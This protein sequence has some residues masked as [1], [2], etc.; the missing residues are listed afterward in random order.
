MQ[1]FFHKF[2]HT[3]V[4]FLSQQEPVQFTGFTPLP[5][6]TEF[7]AHEEQFLAGMTEH[8]GI[9]HPQIG[10]FIHRIA[11]HLVHHGTFQMHHFIVGQGQDIFL[12]LIVTHGKGHA[13]VAAL[14][15]DG[16]QLHIF[17]EIVHP[18]H[19]P[20]EGESQAVSPDLTCHIGPGG[21]FFR[22]GEESRIGSPY[23]GVHVFE[24]FNGLQVLVAAE[25][26]GQPLA[27]LLT[28]VQI[29]H[30]CHRIYPDAI[31]MEF[32]KP[33][34]NIGD[35]EILH[36]IFPIVE[37][38]GSPVR[39]FSQTWIRVLIDTLAV[40]FSQAMGICGKVGRHPV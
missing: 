9:A 29:Q 2:L 12:R 32:P 26:V 3:C 37:N 19:V 34:Q 8:I 18:A 22:Y 31:H 1:Q 6:L 10:I 11:W 25:L 39:M 23:H 15:V 27:V 7:L 13:I 40:K 28:I 20:L 35:Q 33:E 24:E 4:I 38:L 17:A 21:G 36:L 30:G 14:P 5:L 16:I